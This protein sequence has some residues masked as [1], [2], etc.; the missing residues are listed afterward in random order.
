MSWIILIFLYV[1]LY[2]LLNKFNYS[3][4]ARESLCNSETWLV[5]TTG[6]DM[7]LLLKQAAALDKMELCMLRWGSVRQLYLFL[8]ISVSASSSILVLCTVGELGLL[9][10][11]HVLEPWPDLEMCLGCALTDL[12]WLR[13]HGNLP[14]QL[15]LFSHHLFWHKIRQICKVMRYSNTDWAFRQTSG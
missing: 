15:S 6:P 4:E 10:T 11:C 14:V 5:E 8:T 3:A 7:Q 2:T 1:A 13:G 12:A 9:E